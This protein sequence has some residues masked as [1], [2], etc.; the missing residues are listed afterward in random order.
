MAQDFILP[1]RTAILKALKANGPFTS[2]IA[3]EQVYPSTVPATKAWPFSRFASM[4]ASPFLASG[5]DS[6]AFRITLQAFS[7]GLFAGSVLQLPAEDHVINIGSAMKDALDGATLHLSTG[8]KLRLQW[9]Q[10]TPRIDGDEADAWMNSIVFN[11]D[12][13]A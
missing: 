9:V 11:G 12:I 6:S 8:D 5:L 1:A 7:K 10:T 4:I 3:K 13:S 2:L